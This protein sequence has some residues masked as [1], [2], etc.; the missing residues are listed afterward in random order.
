MRFYVVFMV[1]SM[2]HLLQPMLSYTM[3]SPFGCFPVINYPIVVIFLG[4]VIFY[5]GYVFI[6]IF[7]VSPLLAASCVYGCSF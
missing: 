3:A 1:S 4:L 7:D 6:N 5:A 2:A